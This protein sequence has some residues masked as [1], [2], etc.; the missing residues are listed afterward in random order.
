MTDTIKKERQAVQ[1]WLQDASKPSLEN[2][3]YAL[4]HP[5][6]WPQG[7][8]WDYRH[9]DSCAMGL[10]HQLWGLFPK[11]ECVSYDPDHLA[12]KSEVARELAMPYEDVKDIFFGSGDSYPSITIVKGHLWWKKTRQRTNNASVTPEMVADEIDAYIA[13]QK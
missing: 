7:F 2:L 11:T 10:A 3:S 1:D 4:R 5:E 6:T 12:L 8:A 13:R 9:C